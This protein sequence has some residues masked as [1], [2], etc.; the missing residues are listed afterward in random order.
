M[1][2][3]SVCLHIG[4]RKSGTTSLQLMLRNSRRALATQGIQLAATTQDDFAAIVLPLRRG[5]A[6]DPAA[7]HEGV[8]ALVERLGRGSTARRLVTIEALAELPA[9]SAEA[10]VSALTAAGHDVHLVITARPWIRAIP[11]EWQQCV[12]QRSTISYADFVTSIREREGRAA[13]Q[14][15]RRQDLPDVVRRWTT[16]LPVERASVVACPPPS[17]TDGTLVELFSSAVG[18]DPGLLRPLQRAARNTSLS[19]AQTEMLRRVNASLGPRLPSRGGAYRRGI[20]EW[21]TGGSLVTQEREPILLPSGTAGWV[22]GESHRQLDELDRLGVRIVGRPSDLVSDPG[23]PEG[24]AAPAE[25]EVAAVA[26]RTI[27]ELAE[28]RWRESQ[29]GA[30]EGRDGSRRPARGGLLGGWRSRR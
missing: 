21:V 18:I 4:T 24:P 5:I 7:T 29:A 16:L 28:R 23:A 19:L 10:V 6:G 11:S 15:R 13:T 30:G 12:K 20:R 1:N 22:A 26:A 3:A 27:S 14:F 9:A 25:E 17:R 2:T 8:N